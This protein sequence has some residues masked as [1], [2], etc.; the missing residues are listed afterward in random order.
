MKEDEQQKIKETI[1]SKL[2][3]GD[4]KNQ[5]LIEQIEKISAPEL[6]ESF[7]SNLID[8]FVH[9]SIKEEEAKQHWENI[10]KH[11][12]QICKTLERDVGMRLAIFDYFINLNKSLESPLLVEIRLFR[13]AEQ[14]AMYDFLTGLFNRRYF[15][16]YLTKELRRATR[17]DNDFSIFL[18]DLDDFK[19][20]NDTYGHLFGDEVLKKFASFLKYMSRE[21]DVICRF[22][23]EE[24]VIILPETL[25]TGAL[26]YADRLLAAMRKDAFFKQYK[27]TFS[28]G[29]ATYKYGGSS[30]LQLIANADK[31]L[32]HAKLAGKD[33]VL[34][35]KVEN[36]KLF[37][38]PK[39]WQI[40]LQP[41]G[42]QKG[43]KN[44]TPCVTQN[45]SLK[46]LSFDTEEN[47]VIGDRLLLTI[48]L[49]TK[50]KLVLV[51][52]IIWASKKVGA[53]RTY[54]IKYIDLSPEQ[55][56]HLEK[57]LPRDKSNKF[58]PF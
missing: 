44:P 32:Y 2:P 34:T 25:S 26:R 19:I 24:F 30:A 53:E 16:T 29:V 42:H 4:V 21:E 3:E 23:G 14:L 27:V 55:L 9:L 11:Y 50:D 18:L 15:E 43:G 33:Q 17:H 52:E 49:P 38:Y 10:L 22:G 46:G 20:I 5:Y 39:T 57:L 12:E 45:I 28:G 13:E 41:L 40:Y 6:T 47:H 48:E 56:K 31:A 37:R 8:L 36:R 35:S 7:Y 51:G 58:P 54:G 1:I